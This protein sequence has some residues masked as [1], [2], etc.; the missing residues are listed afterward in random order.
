MNLMRL[1]IL[2]IF[3]R[4]YEDNKTQYDHVL[5]TVFHEQIPI[6]FK[7]VPTFC[8]IENLDEIIMYNVLNANG[9]KVKQ[10]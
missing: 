10:I 5:T 9:I 4:L 3:K 2:D 7:N 1:V 8:D 6:N